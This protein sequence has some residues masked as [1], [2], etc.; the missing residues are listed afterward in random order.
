[1]KMK[2]TWAMLLAGAMCAGMMA[3]C[4]STNST[5]KDAGDAAASNKSFDGK[6]SFIISNKDEFQ[7][8]LDQAAKAA[9]EAKGVELSSVDCAADQD[10]VNEA[11]QAA[12]ENGADALMVILA[13]DTRAADAI[14]AAGDVPVVF[15]NRIPQDTDLLD[16]THVYVGSDEHTSGVMQ[17]EMLAEALKAADKK[18][19]NYLMVQ[20]TAGLMHTTLRSEG[21][22]TALK[23]AGIT[24]NAITE[25]IDCGYDRSTAMQ[26]VEALIAGGLDLSKLDV[27]IANNDA[28]AGG[29]VEAIKQANN[30]EL[31]DIMVVGVDGTNAGLAALTNGDMTATVFQNATGQGSV[32]VQAAINLA[33]GAKVNEGISYELEDNCI[34]IPFEKITTDNVGDYY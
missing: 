6:I 24:A 11:I 1:M 8:D 26:Q 29:A 20:G 17:G 27:V 33:S 15:V 10:K 7:S 25:P 19:I 3:G 34:W 4:G 31:G 30:G 21:V 32:G 13:D 5:T 16:E 9:A 18:E 23:D 2:K 28:M 12:V 22:L 14:E